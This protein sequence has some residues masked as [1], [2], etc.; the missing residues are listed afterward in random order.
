MTTDRL[1]AIFEE[2]VARHRADDLE[3]ASRC[4]LRVLAERPDLWFV[5]DNLCQALLARGDFKAGFALYENRFHRPKSV[6]PRPDL[7]TPEW[8]GDPVDGRSVLVWPEQGFGDQIMFAR[9]AAPLR[10]AGARVFLAAHPALQRLFADLPFPVV[11]V[12]SPPPH[13]VWV[14]AGSIPA[15]LGLSAL[16]PPLAL[17][18]GSWGDG[19]GVVTR[20]D[21]RHPNDANRS[22]DAEATGRLQAIPGARSLSPEDTGARDFKDTAEIIAG[23]RLVISVD[24]SVAHL[25][26]SMGKPTWLLLPKVGLDWRWMLGRSHNPWYPAIRP[27]RQKEAGAWGPVVDD[28]F[29]ALAVMDERNSDLTRAG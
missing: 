15:R 4:Y 12:A 8:R 19:I 11:P 2:G 13:D 26:A 9:F 6:V 20:G 5:T 14:S 24:T 29:S 16:P 17:P 25:S 22:L 1:R 27:F 21:P 23:L 7:P 10:E 28:V 3:G 18:T